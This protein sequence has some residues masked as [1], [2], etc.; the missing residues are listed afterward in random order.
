MSDNS[1]NTS[2]D[3]CT[4]EGIAVGLVDSLITISRVL[5]TM[6]LTH[7]AVQEA[8]KDFGTD[9]GIQAII[10]AAVNAVNNGVRK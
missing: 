9:D 7:P 10:V 3:C 1:T 6:D 8:L 2:T 4:P 5:M